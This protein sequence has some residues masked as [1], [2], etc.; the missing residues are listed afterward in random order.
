MASPYFPDIAK[1]PDI[2][3]SPTTPLVSETIILLRTLKAIS[4][5]GLSITEDVWVMSY[6]D[7]ICVLFLSIPT[8]ALSHSVQEIT[9]KAFEL[10]D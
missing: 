10:W 4:E 7:T 6:A 2:P 9:K 5:K 1:R 3:Y 8:T